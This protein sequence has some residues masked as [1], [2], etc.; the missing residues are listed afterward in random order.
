MGSFQTRYQILVS[1]IGRQILN[2]WT[3]SEVPIKIKKQNQNFEKY[4]AFYECE[5]A[6]RLEYCL[7]GPSDLNL[8][9]GSTTF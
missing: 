8:I 6:L 2:H 3:T 4:E 1:C 5:E 7:W 9:P